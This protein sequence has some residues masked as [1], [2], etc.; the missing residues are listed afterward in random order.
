MSYRAVT[1]VRAKEAELVA[2]ACH[3]NVRV[4]F[5]M[6]LWPRES[7]GCLLVRDMRVAEPIVSLNTSCIDRRTA[8]YQ[9]APSKGAMC[10]PGAK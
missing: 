10:M 4:A 7:V 3:T 5:L 8:D 2:I 6:L 1:D 9:Q